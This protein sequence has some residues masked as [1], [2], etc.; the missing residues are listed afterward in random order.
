MLVSQKKTFSDNVKMSIPC[1]IPQDHS[2]PSNSREMRNRA[3]KMRRDKL[4]S[5]IGELATLVPMV[6][7]SSKRMDKTSILRLTATHLRIYQT[8]LNPKSHPHVE[9]PKQINQSMLEEIVCNELGGFMLILTMNGKI[10]FVSHTVESLLGYLQTDLMGQSIYNITL[11]TDHEKLRTYLNS[12]GDL[13]TRWRKYFTVSLKRAGPRSEV[14]VFETVRVMSIHRPCSDDQRDCNQNT[15]TSSEVSTINTVNN[16]ILVLFIRI[17]RPEPIPN[18]LLDISRN[19]YVTRHLVDGR[20]ISCDHRIS[21]I[22]GYMTDEV[23]GLSAFKFMHKDDVRWVITALRQMYD[24]GETMGTSCYRLMSRNSKFI[25]LKTQGF[26]EVDDQGTVES[27]LCINTLVDE[28]EGN[29]SI[30]EMKKKFS[31]LVNLEQMVPSPNT[32]SGIESV[33]DPTQIEQAVMHLIENLPSPGSE[34]CSIS[35]PKFNETKDCDAH[36][37]EISTNKYHGTCKT[38]LKRP[39]STDIDANFTFKRHKTSSSGFLIS[40]A[41]MTFSSSASLSKDKKMIKEEPM[42]EDLHANN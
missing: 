42:Y 38:V 25:Y 34:I 2:P 4:N 26:L 24:R 36:S 35:S 11:P 10:I 31:A 32:H 16:D 3:E 27:F 22:A 30:A 29:Q 8:L 28:K 37:T 9:M 23:S 40:S 14:P 17:N 5:Y 13:E 33:E 15:S 18:R 12:F 6:A 41:S 7:K 21:L 19:E 1:H 20:I 39:P